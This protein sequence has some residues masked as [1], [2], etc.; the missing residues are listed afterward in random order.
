LLD[1]LHEQEFASLLLDKFLDIMWAHL[2]SCANRRVNIWLLICPTTPAFCLTS[3]HFLTTLC[4]CFGLPHLTITLFSQCQCGHS[5]DNLD[6]H[7]LQCHFESEH[8]TH[9][10]LW[11]I[12]ATIVLKSGTHVQRE[13]SHLF[14]HHTQW[15]MDILITRSDF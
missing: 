14:L 7:L 3:I 13:V 1:R 4:T 10:T 12:I 2:C 9:D 11:N 6:I 8:T 5:I 15:W